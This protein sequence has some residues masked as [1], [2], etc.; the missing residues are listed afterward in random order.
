MFNKG[1]H[2]NDSEDGLDENH[3]SPE[4]QERQ[5]E[6][7]SL[8]SLHKSVREKATLVSDAA[9][10][11]DEIECLRD[12]VVNLDR[13]YQSL[14]RSRHMEDGLPMR[15]SPVKK[16]LKVTTMDYHK[17]FHKPLPRRRRKVRKEPSN[18]VEKKGSTS[19]SIDVTN[20]PKSSPNKVE[21]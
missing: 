8:T 20:L 3:S 13:I 11:V 16:R 17:I 9:Y 21:L 4:K 6:H 5:K 14:R 12:A 1:D 15:I 7:P 2:L 18:N 19:M 10:N